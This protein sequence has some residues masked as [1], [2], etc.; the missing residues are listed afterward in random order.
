MTVLLASSTVHP[1]PALAKVVAACL[2]PVA[3]A[4]AG[5][6][7]AA[8][9]PPGQQVK[10]AIQHFAAGLVFAV[11]ATELVPDLKTEHRPVAVVVGF[12]VGIAFMLGLQLL[13]RRS[14]AS[15][16]SNSS[17][18]ALAVVGI[19]VFVDGILIGIGFAEGGSAG[20][21]LV[22]ALTVELLGLGVAL[23]L[24]VQEETSDRLRI[25]GTVTAVSMLLVL[26]GALGTSLLSNLAPAPLSAV[27]AFAT[28]ALLYLVTEEL[29]SEAHE[30]PDT[31]LLTSMFFIGFLAI[32][33]LSIT[34]A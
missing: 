24:A 11:A 19:D 34:A 32:L 13:E 8:F 15:S 30:T 4:T 17:L 25:V 14:E 10:S 26:G 18:V 29:L 1:E 28:V 9:K 16:T 21:L 20:P 12:A 23:A 33:L 27:L 22:I 2:I 7:W 3:A 6:V 31:P 5:A